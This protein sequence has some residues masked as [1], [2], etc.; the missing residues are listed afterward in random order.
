MTDPNAPRPQQP[1]PPWDPASG[2]GPSPGVAPA[3]PPGPA[4]QPFAPTAAGQPAPP[5]GQ[6][7]TA[8]TGPPGTPAPRH[9]GTPAPGF[10]TK[11]RVRLTRISGV[12]VGLITAAVFLILLVIFIAQNLNKVSIHFLGFNGHLSLGLTILIA[13]IIGLVI[14]AVPGSIR[15]LQLRQALKSNTPREQRAGR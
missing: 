5:T 12:W 3:A 10:D 4:G 11:G 15:I 13:A 6:P 8:A 14:A 1:V 9:A 2:Y 7:G